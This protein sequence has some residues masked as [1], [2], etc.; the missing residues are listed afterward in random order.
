MAVA[1]GLMAGFVVA[2]NY[3]PAKE[4]ARFALTYCLQ[5]AGR[6]YRRLFHLRTKQS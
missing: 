1:A 2:T 6:I 4:K 3:L 5:F